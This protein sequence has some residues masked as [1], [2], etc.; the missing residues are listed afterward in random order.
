MS[1]EALSRP[2]SKA[3]ARTPSLAPP[4]RLLIM[5]GLAIGVIGVFMTI[6]AHGNWDFVIP[7]RA[8][9]VLAMVVVG[10]A[11]AVSTV[12]FQTIT[13]NRILT[14][15][16][17][18][19]D[20]LYMLIQ[21]LAVFFLGSAT[22]IGFDERARFGVEVMLMVL[23]SWALYWWLFVTA[24]RGLHLLVLVGIV[25][26]VMFRSVTNLLQRIIDPA[27]F[28]VLQDIGFAS[29]NAVDETLLGVS[30]VLILLIS[31]AIW[32]LRYQ[33]DTIALGRDTAIS[34]GVDYQRAVLVVLA[35]VSILISVS[36]ALVGP[37]TF[38]GLLVAHLA[39]MLIGSP[40]HRFI[41]PAAGMV[42]VI[43]LVFGQLVLERVF[44]FNT[45]LSIIIEFAGG[46][47]FIVLLLRGDTK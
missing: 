5:L 46:L 26:G 15:S 29:F 2:E 44:A 38:F 7:F 41:L 39:Y 36:T 28:A 30:S 9:K 6:E 10:Y 43:I 37:I 3:P 31:V 4:L 34:L 27:E 32:R 25:F 33:L 24:N 21:T 12:M 14:P 47:T 8:R 13:G 40:F 45:S 42:A 22:L 19:F 16:I 11:I 20:A 23:F 1:A 35:F 18:G 17:M